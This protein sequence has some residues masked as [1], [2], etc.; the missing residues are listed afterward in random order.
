V[1]QTPDTAILQSQIIDTRANLAAAERTN[2]PTHPDVVALRRLLTSLETQ[3]ATQAHD[4]TPHDEIKRDADNPAYLMLV[5][6]LHGLD[7]QYQAL[8]AQKQSLDKQVRDLQKDIAAT[9][10]VEQ[11]LQ[12]LA[13]DYDNAQLRYRELKEKKLSA[14][15]SEQMERGRTGERLEVI[16]PPELPPDTH[17]K[18][19]L[20]IL[21]A[22]FLSGMSGFGGVAAAE[23]MSQSVHGPRHFANLIGELPLVVIPHIY[24]QAE[25]AAI[26]RL[27]V[28]SGVAAAI[29]VVVGVILIDQ[30]VMPIDVL[31]SV[32][33]NKFGLS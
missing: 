7:D 10:G 31:W 12:K 25:R 16:E 6:Q 4:P 30:T 17:P 24:T 22:I 21:A 20:L 14:D 18:R 32:I 3:L 19:S 15:M 5:S 27:R 2:G 8:L 13:R 29:A 1:G 28:R 33:L 26:R 23:A 11:E 9:P